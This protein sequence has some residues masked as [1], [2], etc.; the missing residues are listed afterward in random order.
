L[1]IAEKSTVNEDG[2]TVTETFVDEPPDLELEELED[3]PQATSPRHAPARTTARADR[4][5]E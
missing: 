3:E 2:V 5:N 1:A 4:F